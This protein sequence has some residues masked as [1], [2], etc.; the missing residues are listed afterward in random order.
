MFVVLH[1]DCVIFSI[2]VWSDF[3]NIFFLDVISHN[4]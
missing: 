4:N 3:A 1:E 2:L